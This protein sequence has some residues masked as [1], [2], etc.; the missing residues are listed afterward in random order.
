MAALFTVSSK[1]LSFQFHFYVNV[2]G[3]SNP[4]A[5]GSE[6]AKFDILIT[7]TA[8]WF[9]ARIRMTRLHYTVFMYQ[10]PSHSLSST[11]IKNQAR[12]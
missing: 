12:Q 1:A 4:F 6:H 7:W 8:N 2:T 3:L 11:G 9:L 5:Y 10:V